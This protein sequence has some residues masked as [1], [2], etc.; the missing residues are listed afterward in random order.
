MPDGD[1]V[2][3]ILCEF[4]DIRS[5]LDAKQARKGNNRS[6]VEQCFDYLQSAW[7]SR[8]RDA[9]TEPFFAL[10]TDMNEFRLYARRL[11]R[12]QYQRFILSGP[13]TPT[14]PTLLSETP[15]GAFRRFVFWRLFQPDMLLA[16]RGAPLL[17]RLLRD[18]IVREKTIE[19]DFYRE[20]HDYRE[21]VYHTLVEAN[22]GFTGSRGQLVR[23]TQRFLDR[24]IFILFCEDMG[25]VLRYPPALLR[26]LLI[27][28][29]QSRFFDPE[30]SG[31][32]D[33]MRA[34]FRAMREGGNFGP[35]PID[36]FNGGLF[37][38]DPEFDALHIPAKVFC[39]QGQAPTSSPTRARCFTSPPPTTS[40]SAPPPVNAPSASTRSAASS[41]N[42]SPNSKSW[43]PRPMAASPSTN[44][45]SAK[46]TA[47]I[48]RPNGSS[49]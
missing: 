36:R 32:W 10:V 27:E 40:D 47:S 46:P 9:L 8:D 39:A 34:L 26:D 38:E 6:P 1:S 48:T 22:P 16:D 45:A 28:K 49:P 15:A 4:K 30:G 7:Q 33:E 25:R 35:H 20:Y 13:D 19:K 29:S 2:P 3:Q 42:R 43:R 23:L 31:P 44:S 17:D 24:C 5:G 18:Q 21:F 41:S 14:E 37:E 11:G 12:G